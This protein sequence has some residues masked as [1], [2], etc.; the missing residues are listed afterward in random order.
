MTKVLILLWYMWCTVTSDFN[1]CLDEH[2]GKIYKI[3]EYLNCQNKNYIPWTISIEKLN[4]A[5]YK[6]T[7]KSLSI[8]SKTCTTY[9][10]FFGS[11]TNVHAMRQITIDM[12]TAKQAIDENKC[13]DKDMNLIA[14]SDD[15]NYQC[16]YSWLEHKT[17]TIYNCRV[18]EGV[19]IATHS[20]Q[21][22]SSLSNMEGCKYSNGQCKTHTKRHVFWT[23]L[24][25]VEKD[26]IFVGNFNATQIGQKLLVPS[27]SMSFSMANKNTSNTWIDGDFKLSGMPVDLNYNQLLDS[28]N[29][30]SIDALRQELANKFNYIVQLIQSPRAQAEYLCHMYNQLYDVERIIA[31]QNPTEYIQ[32]KLNTTR[33]RAISINNYLMIFPCI[34]I[35]H[36]RLANNENECYSK[37]RIEYKLHN[38]TNYK[39]GYL[40]TKHNT[41]LP[42]AHLVPCNASAQYIVI[43]NT[44]Y[45]YHNGE[46][47][48][49]NINYT[50]IKSLNDINYDGIPISEDFS[51]WIY[52]TT[53]LSHHDINDLILK[54]L[55][56]EFNER[57]HNENDNIINT[58]KW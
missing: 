20:G 14:K 51:K 31:K 6:S 33:L 52:N 34:P 46:Y 42:Y 8:Y 28:S 27:L 9:T 1:I 13:L 30:E 23:V 50:T 36:Y 26:Y 17:N 21:F 37:P 15:K 4:I 57:M 43:N 16:K 35:K 10:G 18:D 12:Q 41:L 25:K 47:E 38:E 48:K 5:E 32:S 49:L 56:N 29:E 58:H 3:P 45:S 40:D 2:Y 11:Q 24:D 44:I 53:E 22:V 54:T 19:V 7:A 55:E 39:V